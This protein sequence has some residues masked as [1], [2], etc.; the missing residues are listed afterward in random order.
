MELSVLVVENGLV[1]DVSRLQDLE[2]PYSPEE[3]SDQHAALD[4]VVELG[5]LHGLI[6][7]PVLG[8]LSLLAENFVVVAA[9]VLAQEDESLGV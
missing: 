1:R 9:Q 6:L 2:G 7:F 3:V 4:L 5:Q 8:L